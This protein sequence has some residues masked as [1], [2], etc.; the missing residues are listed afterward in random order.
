MLLYDAAG[1]PRGRGVQWGRAAE[2]AGRPWDVNMG[3]TLTSQ[4]KDTMVMAVKVAV[5]AGRQWV[6]EGESVKSSGVHC[7]RLCGAGSSFMGRGFMLFGAPAVIS[8]PWALPRP[9]GL[10]AATIGTCQAPNPCLEPAT[11]VRMLNIVTRRT[12]GGRFDAMVRSHKTRDEAH[13][14]R[15]CK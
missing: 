9:A 12:L 4:L 3:W 10:G 15:R 11:G 1:P 13:A 8:S 14:A 5:L 7:Y 6:D 2:G